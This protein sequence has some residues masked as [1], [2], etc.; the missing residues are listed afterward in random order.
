M[1]RSVA[2]VLY[3]IAAFVVLFCCIGSLWLLLS[4][5]YVFNVHGGLL[6]LEWAAPT[7]VLAFVF[8]AAAAWRLAGSAVRAFGSAS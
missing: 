4:V 2:P 5:I 7:E 1:S 6:P 8:V 3:R